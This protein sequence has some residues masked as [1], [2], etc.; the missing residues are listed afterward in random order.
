[1]ENSVQRS[2]VI[3]M[4]EFVDQK[5][6]PTSLEMQLTAS[7][8][9]AKSG[10]SKKGIAQLADTAVEQVLEEGNVF[11]VA[12]ALA[13]LDKF[14]KTVRKDERYI[15]FLRDELAKHHGRVITKGGAKIELCEA[16]VTYDY[17]SNAE[18]NA[19]EEEIKNLQEAKKGLE[20]KLKSIAPGRIGVDHETG[21]VIEGAFKKSKSTYRITLAK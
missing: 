14:A 18:W 5:E 20:E 19:L 6:E 10:I 4:Q 1:M 16:G 3:S 17:S 9:A 8:L 15:Q 21:E 2:K 12:E 13:G 7:L 11:E